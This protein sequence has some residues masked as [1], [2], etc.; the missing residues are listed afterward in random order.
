MAVLYLQVILDFFSKKDV[1]VRRMLDS[2]AG[3]FGISK[4]PSMFIVDK[5]G[6]FEV[7]KR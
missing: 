4:Y 6:T 1:V 5:G 2:D 3:K 7:V